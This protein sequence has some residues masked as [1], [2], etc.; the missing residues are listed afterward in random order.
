MNPSHVDR[1]RQ[2]GDKYVQSARKNKNS[3][4]QKQIVVE[5]INQ[6][7]LFSGMFLS[8]GSGLL[9]SARGQIVGKEGILSFSRNFW[10]F[11]GVENCNISRVQYLQNSSNILEPWKFQGC[12]F[13]Q[14]QHDQH[15][16]QQI[17]S[18]TRMRKRLYKHK[19]KEPKAVKISGGL[20][21]K[22]V[23]RFRVCKDGTILRYRAGYRHR[24]FHKS[25]RQL[26]N[27]SQIV[28]VT[29]RLNKWLRQL[30]LKWFRKKYPKDYMEFYPW[31]IT[32]P[33]HA[34]RIRQFGD[35]YVQKCSK[36][37]KQQ[38]IEASSG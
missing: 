8:R 19:G 6:G 4:K 25:R 38:Q 35:K 10:W 32:N 18:F 7:L 20:A 31:P 27:L 13:L 15:L 16:Y 1:I 29:K 3:N 21:Q 14:Q 36:K 11:G 33:S 28:P 9:N 23:A 37:Y 24:R 5:L 30:G 26:F 22:W 12:K 34:D 17:A 2:F